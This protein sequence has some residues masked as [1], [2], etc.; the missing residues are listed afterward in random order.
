M[1]AATYPRPIHCAR[2]SPVAPLAIV[3]GVPFSLVAAFEELGWRGF[4]LTRLQS[5]ET[6]LVSSAILGLSWAPWH[7]PLLWLGAFAYA[8]TSYGWWL[9]DVL[10]VPVLITWLFNGGRGSLWLPCLFHG[11]ANMASHR[12]GRFPLMG[13]S[14]QPPSRSSCFC[15]LGPRISLPPYRARG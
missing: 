13:P 7:L 9:V 12:T 3:K 4:A 8:Q 1:A 15:S 11:V 5:R 14:W 10:A 2:K 6:A